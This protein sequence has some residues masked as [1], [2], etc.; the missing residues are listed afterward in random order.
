MSEPKESPDSHARRL[1]PSRPEAFVYREV[2]AERANGV[3]IHC[4]GNGSE[5]VDV[6]G[7]RFG[8][9]LGRVW[10]RYCQNWQSV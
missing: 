6:D 7:Y 9:M 5:A 10:E 8:T 4:A 2:G 3:G 1:A